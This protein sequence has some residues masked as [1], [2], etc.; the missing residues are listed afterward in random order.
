MAI[1]TKD[2][3]IKEILKNSKTVAVIGISPNPSKPSYFVSE[4]IQKYGFKMFYV[5]PKYAGQEIL[6]EKVYGS[7]KDI[8]E[9]IDIVDIFRR[10]A[11]LPDVAK[12]AKEKG[13]KTFW[14]QPGTV[15]NRVV[16]ELDKKGY[17]VIVDKCMKIECMRLLED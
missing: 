3:E 12:E 5:N 7:I 17:N 15:N 8:P 6:G 16:E 11:D 1:L 14:F 10:P 4:V 13:F 9:E 2:E